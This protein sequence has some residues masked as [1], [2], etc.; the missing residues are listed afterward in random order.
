MTRRGALT[1]VWLITACGGESESESPPQTEAPTEAPSAEGPHAETPSGETP[2]A[3]TPRTETNAAEVAEA[4]EN[5]EGSAAPAEA[6]AVPSAGIAFG[7]P[8]E[9]AG[10]ELLRAVAFEVTTSSNYRDD[11]AQVERLT[12]GDFRTAWNSATKAEGDTSPE[13]ITVTL[14]DGV[15]VRSIGLTAGY[16]KVDGDRDLFTSNLR[17][18]DVVIRHGESTFDASVIHDERGIQRVDVEG[19]GGEWVI[20]LRSWIAGSRSDW[21]EVIVSELSFLGDVGTAERRADPAVNAEVLQADYDTLYARYLR[22]LGSTPERWERRELVGTPQITTFPIMDTT[23]VLPITL[24][25][26]R[27]YVVVGR[28]SRRRGWADRPMTMVGDQVPTETVDEDG[29]RWRFAMGLESALCPSETL[30]EDFAL[31]DE[32]AVS[33]TLAIWNQSVRDDPASIEDGEQAAFEQ[34]EAELEASTGE[35]IL[36]DS[37]NLRT[38]RLLTTD[39]VSGTRPG[40]EVRVFHHEVEERAYCFFELNNIDETATRVLLSWENETGERRGE[41]T[42]IDVPARRRFVHYRY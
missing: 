27:C 31:E 36:G 17:L 13:T 8:R 34:E 32:A 38:V 21:R 16:T 42:A 11:P 15:R 9:V 33:V 41:P 2:S 7:A 20:E 23:S 35:T 1:L 19:G 6:N 29:E 10:E 30:R 14:P 39:F 37:G 24:E 26:G 40:E 4:P 28:V 12:D 25:A 18:E 22:E 3:E 5:V